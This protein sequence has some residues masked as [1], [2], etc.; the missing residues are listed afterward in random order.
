MR[1]KLPAFQLGIIFWLAQILVIA[2]AWAHLP[3]QLPLF[4]SRPWGKEQ[5][6]S[7][8]G[9]LLLPI[10]SLVISFVNFTFL[11]LIPQEEKLIK[12]IL[13][14]AIAAFNFL[15]LVT[16]VQIIRLVS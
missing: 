8:L 1:L 9:L 6:S 7:P 3:P 5:L 2:L 15:C 10:L 14:N 13:T 16:L 4:Y 11:S 12:Q